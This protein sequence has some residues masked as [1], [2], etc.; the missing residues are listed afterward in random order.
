MTVLKIE[1]KA[2]RGRFSSWMHEL[3]SSNKNYLTAIQLTITI[4]VTINTIFLFWPFYFLIDRAVALCEMFNF[5]AICWS[6][7]QTQFS[8][9]QAYCISTIDYTHYFSFCSSLFLFCQTPTKLKPF[10]SIFFFF[11]S[12]RLSS[13]D[14]AIL[15]PRT[16][17]SVIYFLCVYKTYMFLLP[18]FF[19]SALLPHLT[20]LLLPCLLF[21]FVFRLQHVEACVFADGRAPLLFSFFFLKNVHM[22]VKVHMGLQIR[23]EE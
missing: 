2:R 3:C 13:L 12:R 20:R 6:E 10:P 22:R 5:Y 19:V 17:S 1:A 8:Y 7:Y 16:F 23:E 15:L 4:I 18:L 11:S 9:V 14:W 21:S